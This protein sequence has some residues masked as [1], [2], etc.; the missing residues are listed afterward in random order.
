MT[1]EVPASAIEVVDCP[2]CSEGNALPQGADP[3]STW[4]TACGAPLRELKRGY[5]HLIIT[6]TPEPGYRWANGLLRQGVGA[7]ILSKTFPDKI[8]KDYGLTDAEIFWLSDTTPAP[9][10]LDPKRID[11]EI[12]RAIGKFVKATRGGVVLLDGVETLVVENG[13][14]KVYRFL[15]KVTDLCGLHEITLIVPVAPG[16]FETEQFATLT[17]AFDHAEQL[18]P[19]PTAK[20]KRRKKK[21]APTDE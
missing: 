18:A 3:A 6:E 17:K 2:L 14:D 21:A 10:V 1:P 19:V 5:N 4:C 16:A 15:R 11:F 8:T 13:F 20:P 9:N 12:M 7:L